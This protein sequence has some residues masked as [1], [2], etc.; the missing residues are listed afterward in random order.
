MRSRAVALV[1]DGSSRDGGHRPGISAAGPA[2]APS[3]RRIGLAAVLLAALVAAAL[4]PQAAA[5]PLFSPSTDFSVGEGPNTVINA[6]F[7]ADGNPDLATSNLG[8]YDRFAQLAPP[9]VSVLLGNGSGGFG[10]RTDFTVDGASPFSMTSADFDGD[11][12]PD[13]ATANYGGTV[14]VLLGTG[15]GDFGPRTNFRVGDQAYS[16][17]SADFDGDGNPDLATANNLYGTVSVLL[18]D[19][20]GGF[21]PHTEFPV[22]PNPVWVTTGD[23]DGGR[24]DLVTVSPGYTAAGEPG[25]VTVLHNWGDGSFSPRGEFTAGMAPRAATSVD[26]DGDGNPDL[27]TA[28]EGTREFS[29]F[30]PESSVSVLLG[31]GRSGFG[32]K[33]DFTTGDRPHSVT[34]ADFD[35]DGDPDL[36]TANEGDGSVSVLLGTGSGGFGPKT[37]FALDGASPFSMTSADFDGDGNPDLATTDGNADSV[38]VLLGTGAPNTRITKQPKRKIKRKKK[39]ARV[40][41]K[42]TSEDAHARFRCK[43]NRAAFKRCSSP[44]KVKVRAKRGKGKKHKIAIKARDAEGNVSDP[45]AVKFKVIRKR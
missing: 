25:T 34:S 33:T 20:S 28:N 9:S 19:G 11:G 16:V 22:G 3:P 27:A 12:N 14:S 24:P 4:A 17:T 29:D 42:F 13:L 21:G 7:D 30:S 37:D 2:R 36:A 10:P 31:D 18:G 8:R 23:F 32:P 38:S 41:V 15:D 1:A 5:A 39:K 35:G 45:A 44:Y 6:D 26:F 40:K 43:L